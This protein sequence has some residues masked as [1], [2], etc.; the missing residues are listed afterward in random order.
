[1][2]PVLEADIVK[3]RREHDWE[4]RITIDELIKI[5][6]DCDVQS[7]GFTLPVEGFEASR[8]KGFCYTGRYFS[9]Y[10]QIREH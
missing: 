7:V 1:V 9:V 4:P 5:M 2:H 10:E 8:C 3:A 6:V